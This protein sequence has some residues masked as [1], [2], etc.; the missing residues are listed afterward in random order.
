L[1]T[2][3]KIISSHTADS[4]Q[5]KQEANGTVILPPIVFPA[6]AYN[7]RASVTLTSCLIALNKWH[8][9]IQHDNN[10]YEDT[11]HSLL[12]YDTQSVS[13]FIEML[14]VVKLNRNA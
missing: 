8:H 5:V 6:L 2:K 9:N 3:T 12:N 13:F 1:Q 7:S 4:K 11:Q 10:Q 14:S